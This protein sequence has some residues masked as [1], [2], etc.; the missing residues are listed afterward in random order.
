MLKHMKR[1][2]KFA[3]EAVRSK[4]V[5]LRLVSTTDQLADIFTKALTKARHREMSAAI[6]GHNTLPVTSVTSPT[7]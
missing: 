3:I 4:D 6:L 5:E 7:P 1:H 2:Y